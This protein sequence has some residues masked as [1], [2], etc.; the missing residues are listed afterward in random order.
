MLETDCSKTYLGPLSSLSSPEREARLPRLLRLFVRKREDIS[1]VTGMSQ[2]MA[3]LLSLYNS[4]SDTFGVFCYIIERIFPVSYFAKGDRELGKHTEFRTFALLAEKLRPRLVQTLKAVF[5]PRG[6]PVTATQT[7]EFDYSPFVTT[8]KR[9]AE[10][11][12]S[13]LF[14]SS[15]YPSDLL[16]VWDCLFV[17]GFEAAHKVALALLSRYERFVRNTVKQET[18]SL[19]MGTGVDV[20][21]TAGNAARL[22]LTKRSERQQ[23]EKLVRK[24]L[25]KSTY[26]AMTREER[27][28]QAESLE[29]S[30]RERISRL[31]I[32]KTLF[33]EKDTPVE[34]LV[35]IFDELNRLKSNDQISRKLFV[36]TLGRGHGLSD[37]TAL[38]LF[39]TFDQCGG[40]LLTVKEL[41]VGLATMCRASLDEKL[42]L[43]FTIFDEEK[44]GAI[45]P[46]DVLRLVLT[47]EKVLDWRA[48]T[49]AE[50]SSGMFVAMDRT[51]SGRI[52]LD[53]FVKAFK[54]SQSTRGVLEMLLRLDSEDSIDGDDIRIVDF[55]C[56]GDFSDMHSP[57]TSSDIATPVSEH[58]EEVPDPADLEARLESLLENDLREARD[59][60]KQDNMFEETEEHMRKLLDDEESDSSREVP[61]KRRSLDVVPVEK[62]PAPKKHG[63]EWFE[64]SKEETNHGDLRSQGT[65]PIEKKDIVRRNGCARLCTKDMCCIS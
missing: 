4:D 14:T 18:T 19:C 8:A 15:L 10:T 11:W 12:F 29:N 42:M 43:Y 6:K 60:R 31:R 16:R 27:Y 28:S 62:P 13:T 53:V 30:Q 24:A 52:A 36:T 39:V 64:E 40:D 34:E 55:A 2:I 56:S 49:F 57:I 48:N 33:Q 9:I 45:D 1:Y 38:N 3:V 21:I 23:V 41:L 58:E 5:H 44:M 51:P 50:L 26:T 17:C 46:Q 65:L 22:K 35:K 25:G 7:R 61:A 37:R 54:E 32:S 20:L 63:R 59:I 47:L